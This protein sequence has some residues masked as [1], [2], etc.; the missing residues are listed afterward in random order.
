MQCVQ[1]LPR[2]LPHLDQARR[3]RLVAHV[4]DLIQGLDGP[5]AAGVPYYYFQRLE[6][7]T[8]EELRVPIKTVRPKVNQSLAKGGNYVRSVASLFNVLSDEE[9]LTLLRESYRKAKSSDRLMMIL[10]LV[11]QYPGKMDASLEE[12]FSELVEEAARG[13]VGDPLKIYQTCARHYYNR[14]PGNENAGFQA[15]LLEKLAAGKPEKERAGFL[16]EQ[17]K[18]WNRAGDGERALA[19]AGQ[20]FSLALKEEKT[21]FAT[22]RYLDELTRTSLD[23]FLATLDA[24]EEEE[25]QSVDLEK[26]RIA[27]VSHAGQADRLL[28]VLRDAVGKFPKEVGFHQELRR[29][30]ERQGRYYEA[31][32]VLETLIELEPDQRQH[33]TDLAAA[34]TRLA[35]PIKARD[36][37]PAKTGPRQ[38]AAKQEPK[39]ATIVRASTPPSTNA[40]PAAK[41]IAEDEGEAQ[42]KPVERATTQLIKKH[43][44]AGEMEDAR[45]ALRGLWRQFPSLEQASRMRHCHAPRMPHSSYFKWPVSKSDDTPK[46]TT[47]TPSRG[48]LRAFLVLEP[49]VSPYV[50]AVPDR[51]PTLFSAI[52]SEAF[53]AGE[54]ETWLRTFDPP[55]YRGGVFEELLQEVVKQRVAEKGVGPFVDD[56]IAQYAKGTLG[57]LD[58]HALFTALELHPDAGGETA[59]TFL[60]GVLESLN[61]QDIWKVLRTARCLAERGDKELALSLYCWCGANT[62]Y[63]RGSYH[64]LTAVTADLLVEEIREHFEG[65]SRIRALERVL[66][67]ITP[68]SVNPSS[69]SEF[70]RFVLATWAAELAP[71][72]V[73]QHC[74]EIC[75]QVVREAPTARYRNPATLE[76]AT[77]FLAAAG[78]TEEALN[79]SQHAFEAIA[80]Q[81]I[82]SS[83]RTRHR[84]FILQKW[85]PEDLSRWRH[86]DRWLSGF[87]ERVRQ[88]A[89]SRVLSSED[90]VQVLSLVAV[91]QHQNHFEDAARAT[92]GEIRA[93]PL[94]N[95]DTALWF[96]DAAEI[97]GDTALALEI[98]TTLLKERRLPVTRVAAVLE[99]V[100][101]QQGVPVALELAEQTLAYTWER[102]FLET[103]ARI[104]TDAG[105]EEKAQLWRERLRK[106]WN[107]EPKPAAT[108][109]KTGDGD[110]AGAG[111]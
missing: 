26:R 55:A 34:W 19:A 102:S 65:A 109:D 46:K 98:S 72:E 17:A 99:S 93:L 73:Y 95:T 110:D 77:R 82:S 33:R 23:V 51:V 89:D 58:Q 86:A 38:D 53:A 3:D 78:H 47:P 4:K 91:R 61:P 30:L 11:H 88:W 50:R 5:N 63:G 42:E 2:V 22:L 85:L 70:T 35:H 14:K 29:A 56:A 94:T 45:V 43:V 90:A 7:L 64:G 6:Q 101:R 69:Q 71:H 18:A 92:L 36:A 75:R 79:G 39:P 40:P 59:S 100:A 24:T 16:V 27:L 104:C 111:G 84:H 15:R 31:I 87:A 54:M 68:N 32:D 74:P 76:L 106:A 81:N 57:V 108:V 10:S 105:D 21:F 44:E 28:N 66:K 12:T 96:H 60:E 52:G 103:M 83:R 8:G 20:A 9:Y 37:V 62:S 67:L 97:T 1:L 80:G 107:V 49:L 41:Q 48:G 25:G 13:A